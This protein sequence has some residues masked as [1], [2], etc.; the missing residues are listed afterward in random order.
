SDECNQFGVMGVFGGVGDLQQAKKAL[1]EKTALLSMSQRIGQLGSWVMDV[2]DNALKWSNETYR[3]FGLE[4]GEFEANYEEFLARV[5]PDDRNMVHHAYTESV[6]Q[7]TDHYEIEHRIIRQDNKEVRFVHEKCQHQRDTAGRIIRSVGIVQD[8]T[9]RKKIATA[10]RQAKE[11]A[12]KA[13]H[14]KSAFLANMSHEIR[15][16]MNVIIGMNKLIRETQLT[17]QQEEYAEIVCRSS[18]ILFALIKDILDFSK[19]EAGRIELESIPFQIRELINGTAKMLHIEAKTKGLVLSSEIADNIPQLVQGDPTRLCQI[20]MNLVNNAIKFTEQGKITLKTS[21]KSETAHQIIIDFSVTDTGIGI[22]EDRLQA[23]FKPFSQLDPS[24]TR[25]YGGTGLGLV[26]SSSIIQ[27]MGGTIKVKT[28]PGKGSTFY[29]TLCFDKASSEEKKDV[30]AAGEQEENGSVAGLRGILAE[31]YPLNQKLA[32]ILLEK[33][34]ISVTLACNGQEA[35]EAARKDEYDFILMDLQMPVMD[36]LEA[37][38]LLRKEQR[39]LPIIALT[40]NATA[41][42]RIDC[43]AAGMDDYLSK[44]IDKQKLREA[45]FRQVK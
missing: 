36:G 14:A 18:D 34:G 19:I 17:P 31:D 22:P 4:P 11:G 44:P 41:Q 12:E 1:N 28:I 7:G 2:P 15:T 42:D 32:Q 9:E 16:P 8:I 5:H 29:C 45:I 30:E 13:N 3:I 43:L 23:L 39:T 20:I 21:L 10:L 25:K 38:K 24:T 35:V 33:L 27:M 40:A 6:Q 26:I 37:T